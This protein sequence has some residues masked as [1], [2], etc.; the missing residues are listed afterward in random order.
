[1]IEDKLDDIAVGR[2]RAHCPLTLRIGPDGSGPAH[3]VLYEHDRAIGVEAI[4]ELA[5]AGARLAVDAYLDVWRERG[6]QSTRG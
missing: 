5:R 2:A 1:M 4:F 3:M 6:A